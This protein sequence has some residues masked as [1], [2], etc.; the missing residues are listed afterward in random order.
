L[1]FPRKASAMGSTSHCIAAL[2]PQRTCMAAVLKGT[3]EP[4][5]S[6][7]NSLGIPAIQTIMM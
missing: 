5:L 6:A 1:A 3:C 7:E 4:R 2:A